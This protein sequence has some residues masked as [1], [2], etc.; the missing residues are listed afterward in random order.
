MNFRG[1]PENTKTGHAGRSKRSRGEARDKSTSGGVHRQYVDA[2]RIERNEAYG[3][4]SAAGYSRGQSVMPSGLSSRKILSP[5]LTC[6][7]AGET[8]TRVSAPI[9]TVYS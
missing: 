5:R 3:S 7:A 9:S 1:K 2:R 4:F 6:R 8:S